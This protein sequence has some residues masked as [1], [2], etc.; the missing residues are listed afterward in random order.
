MPETPIG[1]AITMQATGHVVPGTNDD[2]SDTDEDRMARY[3]ADV[4]LYDRDSQND[5][6]YATC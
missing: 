5:D 2:K 4:H 3:P 1:S 6:S